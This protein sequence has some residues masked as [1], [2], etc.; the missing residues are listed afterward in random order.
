MEARPAGCSIFQRRP[1]LSARSVI[2]ALLNLLFL[3]VLF[4][5]LESAWGAG[6]GR[7]T[8]RFFWTDLTFFAGQ[9]LLFGG[10][11][12]SV[13]SWLTE[14]LGSVRPIAPVVALPLLVQ[15]VLALVLGEL[16]VYG[17]HRAFHA[18]PLLWRFHSVHH[19]TEH[20]DWLAAHRE[21]PVDGFLV[22]L[23]MNLP[24]LLLGVSLRPLAALIIFRGVWAVMI[25]SN[26]RLPLGPLGFLFGAPEL[27]HWH[28]RREGKVENF[29]NLAPWLDWLFG[30]YHRPG[31]E[32]RWPLGVAQPMP[33]GY[34]GQLLHP[35]VPPRPAPPLTGPAFAPAPSRLRPG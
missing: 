20:L 8:K 3:G 2:E 13:L 24:A 6:T 23:A 29:A 1:L 34:V 17:L 18:V 5:P 25:H 19:N 28:H 12:F 30:T 27:H 11:V 7:G 26:T 16:L 22:Q 15:G 10:V 31:A 14:A 21:H 33:Q 9:Y 35:L 4:V 32:E